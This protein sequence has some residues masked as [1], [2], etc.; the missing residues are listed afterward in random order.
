MFVLKTGVPGDYLQRKLGCGQ[1][2]GMMISPLPIDLRRL[3]GSVSEGRFS[4]GVQA[5]PDHG[6]ERALRL[7]VNRHLPDASRS[8]ETQPIKANSEANI[9]R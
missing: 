5:K 4:D 3:F 7:L 2:Y 1:G 8:A 9:V 6:T